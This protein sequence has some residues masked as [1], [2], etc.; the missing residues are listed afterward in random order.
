LRK[1]IT[2]DFFAKEE[3]TMRESVKASLGEEFL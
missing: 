2:E 3:N 1:E